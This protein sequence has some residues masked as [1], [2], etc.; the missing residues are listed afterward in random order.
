MGLSDSVPTPGFE[1]PP[2]HVETFPI[3]SC[4]CNRDG[5]NCLSFKSKPG[6]KFTDLADAEEIARD[7]NK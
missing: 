6:V 4:V 7:W 3:G 5:F 1:R 2:Y